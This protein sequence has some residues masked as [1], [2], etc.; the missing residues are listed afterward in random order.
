[1]RSIALCLDVDIQFGRTAL[2]IAAEK[3]RHECASIILANGADVNAFDTVPGIGGFHV[4]F[5]FALL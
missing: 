2:M 3:G 4:P 1:M 5:K